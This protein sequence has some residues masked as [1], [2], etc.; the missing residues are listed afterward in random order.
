[1]VRACRNIA[2]YAFCAGDHT[3]HKCRKA[4]DSSKVKYVNCRQ[5]G[6]T[7]W[8]KVCPIQDWELEQLKMV[9]LN[10]LVWFRE[11]KE[12]DCHH[13]GRL[14]PSRQPTPARS[15][16]PPAS[17]APTPPAV[18]PKPTTLLKRT[19][20]QQGSKSTSSSSSG[21]KAQP[22]PV[23]ET[24]RQSASTPAGSS[25]LGSRHRQGRPRKFSH[26]LPDQLQLSVSRP[27]HQHPQ[28]HCRRPA[29]YM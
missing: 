5:A 26:C 10:T 4:E 16:P 18:L 22:T 14:P 1:M 8:M 28:G 19:H 27:S 6:H 12:K 23:V 20:D 2:K 3:T 24:T 7:A 15:Q 21:D 25:L 11:G 9:C 29:G 17:G 13:A